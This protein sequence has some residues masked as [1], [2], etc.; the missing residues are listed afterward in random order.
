MV[1]KYGEGRGHSIVFQLNFILTVG[2]DLG[3]VTC[4]GSFV[5]LFACFFKPSISR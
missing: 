2:L 4:T 1:I 5:C 3:P